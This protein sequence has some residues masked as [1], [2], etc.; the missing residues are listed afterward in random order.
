MLLLES[1]KNITQ[2]VTLILV[3]DNQDSTTWLHKN[4]DSLVTANKI[5]LN[6]LSFG[7]HNH[8]FNLSQFQVNFNWLC[9]GNDMSS[10]ADK[11]TR[12]LL[13]YNNHSLK[14]LTQE[15]LMDLFLEQVNQTRSYNYFGIFYEGYGRQRR[16]DFM[17]VFSNSKKSR[18]SNKWF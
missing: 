3:K 1:S 4:S 18:V 14:V 13:I 6:I 11:L 12:L 8:N 5:L 9:H 16:F 2:R 17:W 7:E 10:A 15:I